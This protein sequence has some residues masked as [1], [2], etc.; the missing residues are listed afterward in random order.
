MALQ[1]NGNR[2]PG[3][4]F[5]KGRKKTGGRKKGT[6][7]KASVEVRQLLST[8]LHDPVYQQRFVNRL[9]SGKLSPRL[10]EM[11]WAYV[12][13]KPAQAVDV[14]GKITLEDVLEASRRADA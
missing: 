11:A 13:G 6:P 2:G 9:R 1:Q 4:P 7:N 5:Q 3:R 12:L 10:E 14:K 8:A